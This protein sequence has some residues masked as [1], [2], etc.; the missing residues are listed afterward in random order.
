MFG[1]RKS[2]QRELYYVSRREYGN[3][4]KKENQSFHGLRKFREI[5]GEKVFS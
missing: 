3:T 5:R 1:R 4:K 2:T